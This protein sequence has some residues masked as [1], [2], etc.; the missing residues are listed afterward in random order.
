MNCGRPYSTPRAMSDYLL[1]RDSDWTCPGF[2][3]IAFKFLPVFN[4]ADYAESANFS[5]LSVALSA[6]LPMN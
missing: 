6:N 3:L 4:F 5:G 1:E 2:K